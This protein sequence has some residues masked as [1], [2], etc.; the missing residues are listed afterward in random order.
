MSCVCLSDANL[1]LRNLVKSLHLFAF[2]ELGFDNFQYYFVSPPRVFRGRSPTI[3]RYMI[4]IIARQSLSSRNNTYVDIFPGH[5]KWRN[6]TG[7]VKKGKKLSDFKV[8]VDL[9]LGWR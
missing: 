3:S 9:C 4:L 1:S 2:Q 5:K 7:D 6:K 8:K